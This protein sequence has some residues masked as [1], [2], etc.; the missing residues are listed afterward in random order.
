MA[1]LPSR[2]VKVEDAVGFRRLK[3]S[4]SSRDRE[5]ASESM[6]IREVGDRSEQDG[7]KAEKKSE[8]TKCGGMDA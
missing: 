8:K 2:G 3:A 6:S 1:R 4:I 7:W 5:A